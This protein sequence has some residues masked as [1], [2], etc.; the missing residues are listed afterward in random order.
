MRGSFG[1]FYDR[2][3]LRPLA[4]ALLSANNTNDVTRASLLSYTFTPGQNGAPTFPNTFA[5]VPASGAVLNFT[6]MNQNIQNPYAEQA[7]LEVEQQFTLRSS[8][9]ISYQH[10]RGVHLITSINE[11][12]N[13]D[14]S[15]PNAAYGNSKA[16]DSKADS[17]Y[18]GLAVS[19]VQRPSSWASARIS[20]TW[21]K[22]IDD[23]GEFFFSAPVNNF[24]PGEDRSR[25]DDDQRHR[26]AFS[27]TLNSPVTPARSFEA[28]LGHDWRLSG[29][30]Q[31][32]S[33]LPFNVVTGGTTKQGTTQRPCAA[34]F[35]LTANGGLN[36][37][38]E[39]LAGTMIGRNAG[40]GFDFFTLNPR[41]SRVFPL[42]E[43]VRLEAIAEAFNAL[44]HRNDMIPNGTFGTNPYPASANSTF[45]QATAVGDPRS[46][47]VAA[48]ISF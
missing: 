42:T 13:P 34:G 29:I 18:D 27:A 23:V 48:R 15:R 28:R 24:F 36:P 39:A 2:V 32:T 12:I 4:N 33:R 6:L 38:T 26:L 31:Y 44:N 5:T 47:Q 40:V 3:A 11:N 37:C 7:S 20:Y 21:S 9:G 41:L 30:L 16:Y 25:S 19:F 14:G 45:G 1:L 8:L 46:I 43:R 35:S 22:A 10:L 17:Y